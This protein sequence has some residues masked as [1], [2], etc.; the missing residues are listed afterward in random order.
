MFC[1]N[2]GAPIKIEANFCPNCGQDVK[3]SAATREISSASAPAGI[4][5]NLKGLD[6]GEVVL[7]DTGTFPITYAKNIMSSIN[8]KLYLTNQR[9][10]FKAVAL[11]GVG[12]VSVGGVFIPNPKDANKSKEYFG[13]PLTEIT[14]VEGGWANITVQAAGQ[15]YKFGGMRK[16]K[17]WQEAIHKAM[18]R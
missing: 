1:P 5:S 4:A 15:K 17:E 7:I 10:I 13:I 9:L 3:G 2:C 8:G 12:G 16:T 18:T 14:A 11:Q 6:A